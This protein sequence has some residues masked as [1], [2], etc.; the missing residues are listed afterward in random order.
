MDDFGTGYCQLSYLLQLPVDAIKIDR[1]FVNGI[2]DDETSQ[3]DPSKGA[4]A[5]TLLALS[6][7]LDLDVTAEGIESPQQ[8]WALRRQGCNKFQ[9][10]LF[11]APVPKEQVPKFS[12]VL[13]S[14][15][16]A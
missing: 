9:G 12:F 7:T 13:P 10:Y 5:K 14:Q 6:K 1:T 16:N 15:E 3:T 4:I 8:F 11:S 2:G